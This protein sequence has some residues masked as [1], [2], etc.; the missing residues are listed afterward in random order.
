MNKNFETNLA[1]E[2]QDLYKENVSVLKK[3]RKTRNKERTCKP[4]HLIMSSTAS[5]S[6]NSWSLV[7]SVLSW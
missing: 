2:V 7:G 1:K 3:L 5:G 6:F 4:N